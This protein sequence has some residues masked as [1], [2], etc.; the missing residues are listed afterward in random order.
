MIDR[1]KLAEEAKRLMGGAC[2]AWRVAIDGDG[3]QDAEEM[4][5]R[6]IAAIDAL[7]A[8]P[9]QLAV[10]PNREQFETYFYGSRHSDGVEKRKHL[11]DRLPD[12]TYANDH[13]QRHWWTWQ[14]AVRAL[15]AIEAWRELT[16]TNRPEPEVY[17][18]AWDGKT[19]AVDW[20]GSL[21]RPSGTA[22]THWLP[23]EKPPGAGDMYGRHS[24]ATTPK[25]T[26]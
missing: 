7:A 24:L 23:F 1:K 22:Y 12:D 6:A 19:V 8:D 13:T 17:V 14:N 5:K 15:G 2:G 25:D 16:P 11:L 10:G 18:L 26:E 4:Q 21:L 9:P 3:F 20:F